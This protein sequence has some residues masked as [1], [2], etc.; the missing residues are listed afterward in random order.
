MIPRTLVLRNFLSYGEEVGPLDFTGFSVAC[1]TGRNGHGKSA[2][3]DAITWAL[4]GEARKAAYSRTPDGD[5]LRLGADEMS[6]EFS[7][8]LNEQIY[9]VAREHRR[10][11]R[12]GRLEFRVRDKGDETYRLLTGSTKKETQK[13][14]I[15]TLRLDYRTFVNSSFLQ[16]GKANAFTRQSPQDRKA[17]LSNILGL[18]YYERLLEETKARLS[19]AK[20]SL[21]SIED[22]LE[23]IDQELANEADVKAQENELGASLNAVDKSMAGLRAQ[24]RT[25]QAR[26]A[27][28]KRNQEK[29]V[30]HEK[31][32][33]DLQTRSIE[34]QSA[35]ERL[36]REQ[37]S[38]TEL[39]AREADIQQQKD[40]N[41]QISAELQALL[42]VE[43]LLQTLETTRRG[44]E[45]AIDEERA[46]LRE[47]LASVKSEE[48]Q[49]QN[50][51][52]EGERILNRKK[53][54]EANYKVYQQRLK[55]EQRFST[56]KP[57]YDA[58]MKESKELE[59][60]I[61]KE[62][63]QLNH[64]LAEIKGR[65]DDQGALD[66]Q[67]NQSQQA[68]QELD[69]AKLELDKLKQSEERVTE[70]GR[71]ARAAVDAATSEQQ[72]LEAA[73]AEL[74]EKLDLLNKGETQ[75]C[76][77]CRQPLDAHS[78]TD[79]D[80]HFKQE[81]QQTKA[82]INEC[83]T[84]ADKESKRVNQLREQYKHDKAKRETAEKHLAQLQLQAGLLPQLQNQWD[85]RQS[86]IKEAQT[87]ETQ[88]T[89]KQFALDARTR[90]GRIQ[91]E[92]KTLGYDESQ[93]TEI[94]QQIQARQDD[95]L[96]WN[97]LQDETQRGQQ[98]TAQRKAVQQKIADTE[99]V[100]QKDAFAVEA[101][102]ALNDTLN[103]MAPL[104][105]Q[106]AKRKA[107][108]DEQ[109]ALKN[110]LSEWN[111]LQLAKERLPELNTEIEKQRA[112]QAQALTRLKALEDE[113]KGL[114][115]LAESMPEIE[116]RLAELQKEITQRE[117]AQADIQRRLGAVQE[118]VKRMQQ[119]K[120]ERKEAKTKRA[121]LQCDVKLYDILRGAFSRD[122]I[123]AL[124]VERALPELENDANRLL[125]RL[126]Q[127]ACSVKLE[128]Q[129][130][131]KS[132]AMAETLDIKISDELGTRD[133]ELFSGGE[134][135]R[136]D[137]ALRIALSKLLC[138]RAGSKLQLL[139]IDEGFG[140]QDEEGLSQIVQAI[141]EIQD[142]FE[143]ILVITHL[144]DLKEQF[145]V[146]IEVNKEP[147]AGSRFQVVH[148]F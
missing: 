30:Q 123:P 94:Q 100:L 65:I 144:E 105:Q 87:I 67:V 116:S 52:H 124:I 20:A 2:L 68:K 106:L 38:L 129:R 21:R 9:Q 50:A 35:I 40:R 108:H 76:P 10:N 83:K 6:V 91:H 66:K 143:K 137:L 82:Q 101:R 42:E 81:I 69:K 136:T 58:L 111:R 47:A 54:I 49:I 113:M 15:E 120:D 43:T 117:A 19:Q 29:R 53:E 145:M 88:L 4:W 77:L 115:P 118:I 119:R 32:N 26:Q 34:I 107:L 63:Q 45:K 28:F 48:A 79:L 59:A 71:Q 132:G 70:Q 126:T 12:S 17:I 99:S 74:N 130:Q 121:D 80:L 22:S 114:Q 86:V 134:A 147:G 57:Q 93:H 103:T 25:Q 141:D 5:L 7:F 110:A 112:N 75:A 102:N 133:Y 122:G 89:D 24:E 64:R 51:M 90:T 39:I 98:R 46:K 96:Q 61:E 127:G 36:G 1:L 72:R 97:R 84:N 8:E 128:S 13:R 146:R 104:Q 125:H 33:A 139:V 3:L 11:K 56:L 95:V 138:R 27:E 41:D 60:Q 31:E 55:R 14:I 78:Q 44:H 131:R 62:T 85:A 140:T 73:L 92:L 23:S 135:F 18:S 142:E 16:Q 109:A 148:T 37:T